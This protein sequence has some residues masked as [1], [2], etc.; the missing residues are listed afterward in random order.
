MKYLLPVVL[1]VLFLASYSS[2]FSQSPS[3]SQFNFDQAYRDYLYNFDQYRKA[4][5]DYELYRSQYLKFKTLK[6]QENAY[7]A[8]LSLLRARD[9]TVKTYLTSLRLKSD[10]T[11]GVDGARKAVLFTKI[12]QEVAWYTAHNGSLPSAGTLEDLVGDSEE[13]RTRFTA[14]TPLFYDSLIAIS[15]GKVA[16]FREKEEEI[17]KALKEKT[18]EIRA[19]GDKNTQKSERWQLDTE[20]KI[21]RCKEKEAE[22][23]AIIAK[24]GNSGYEVATSYNQALFRLEEAFQY[25]KEANSYLK[26][27]VNEIKFQD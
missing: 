15:G 12:D 1:V 14:E 13:A 7:G 8:T 23:Y 9:E 19:N 27:I 22:A 17:L 5:L 6:S 25:L 3:P 21:T 26:E 10:E 11:Q 20:E 4:N 24:T 2:V 16:Y 18:T